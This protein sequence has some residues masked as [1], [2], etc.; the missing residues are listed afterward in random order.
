[1]GEG[2]LPS[3]PLP[4]RAAGSRGRRRPCRR[5]GRRPWGAPSRAAPCNPLLLLLLRLLLPRRRSPRP[6]RRRGRRW[7]A[8][9][10][11]RPRRRRGS[12][13]RG[14]PWRMAARVR[15]S[16]CL[17]GLAL[18]IWE[19]GAGLLI[20]GSRGGEA[21]NAVADSTFLARRRAARVPR[22]VRVTCESVESGGV[23]M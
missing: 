10:A 5:R 9:T 1:M 18:W 3:R 20:G 2:S 16:A 14:D 22:P 7:R 21:Q 13:R 15:E 8:A 17:A 6:R 19:G 23:R 12:A 11:S 4:R